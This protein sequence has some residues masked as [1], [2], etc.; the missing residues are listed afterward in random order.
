MHPPHAGVAPAP[1]SQ[2]GCTVLFKLHVTY[3]MSLAAVRLTRSDARRRP[4]P[5]LQELVQGHG[6]AIAT[7]DLVIAVNALIKRA[8]ETSKAG[9]E[10]FLSQLADACLTQM[11]FTCHAHVLFKALLMQCAFECPSAC[12]ACPF[13]VA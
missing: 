3:I 4:E 11:T 6:K 10:T 8:A 12:W 7:A 13:P 5:W 9:R 2:A 1:H